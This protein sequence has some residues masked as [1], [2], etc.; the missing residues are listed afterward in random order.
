MSLYQS[1]SS[2]GNTKN[3]GKIV[4]EVLS[5][6]NEVPNLFSF[7]WEEEEKVDDSSIATKLKQDKMDIDTEQK[8]LEEELITDD[9]KYEENFSNSLVSFLLAA[10]VQ[11]TRDQLES[12]RPDSPLPDVQSNSAPSMS[13]SQRLLQYLQRDIIFKASCSVDPS[14]KSLMK[15]LCYSKLVIQHAIELLD[16]AFKVNSSCFGGNPSSMVVDNLKDSAGSLVPLDFRVQ[17]VLRESMCAH[18]LHLL[19]TSLSLFMTRSNDR[20]VA[21]LLPLLSALLT[22][23][24]QLAYSSNDARAAEINYQEKLKFGSR[25]QTPVEVESPHKYELIRIV[26]VILSSYYP[27]TDEEKNVHIPGCTHLYV[28]FDPQCST[29][30][31]YGKTKLHSQLV[32]LGKIFFNCTANR[33]KWS[34]Y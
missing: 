19:S 2:E 4:D 25:L 27:N 13:P 8:K 14:S 33:I 6:L 1:G 15:L 23:L 11:E 17:C 22:V 26:V 28:T 32:L 3:N 29:D 9:R 18:L 30:Q 31:G 7:L 16:L 21:D 20:F 10:V 12:L 34:Q 24:D 5:R